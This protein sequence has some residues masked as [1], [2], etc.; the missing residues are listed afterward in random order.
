MDEE[1]DNSVRSE[2]PVAEAE[3]GPGGEADGEG[4]KFFDVKNACGGADEVPELAEGEAALKEALPLAEALDEVALDFVA[5]LIALFGEGWTKCFYSRNWQCRVAAL[6]HLSASMSRRLE[7]LT[8]PEVP[9]NALGEL[10]DGAMRAVHEG[11][12][13]QNVRVYAEACMSVTAVVPAFCGAV[14]GRLLV[15]HLAPLLRQLCARM[16]DS[17]EVVPT[18]TTQA[19]FRLLNPPTGNIVSPIAIAMLILRHLAPSKEEAGCDSPTSQAKSGQGKGNPIGWLCRLAALRDLAKEH[20]KSIVQ[21]PGSTNPG[22]WLRLAEGLK[23]SD[24]TVRHE[25]MRLY[26]LVCKMHLKSMGD[27][28]AQRPAREVW[29]AALPVDVP[30]KSMEQVRKYLKLPEA[31]QAA[32]EK[33]GEAL[34]KSQ[35]LAMTITSMPWEVPKN[36]AVWAGCAPEVLTVLSAPGKGDEKTVLSAL[37]A[38]GKGVGK[39][40]KAA[41]RGG[42]STDEAFAHICRAIQQALAFPTGADRYVFLCAVEL[43]QMAV[44]QLSPA[45]SGLDINMGL[46]KIFPTL[47]ERTAVTGATD[48]KVGVASDKFVQQ[49]AKH[50]KVGCEAVTKMV[51]N[52]VARSERPVRP[53]VLLRTLLSDFG[54]RLCAQRDVVTLL[55][56]AIAGHLERIGK[57]GEEEAEAVRTQLI[58]VLATC[59]QFSPETVHFCM[60]E[61]DGSQ[62][63]LLFAALADAPNPRLVALGATAAEQDSADV[64]AGSAVRAASRSRGNSRQPSPASSP[65]PSPLTRGSPDSSPGGAGRPPAPLPAAALS[66]HNSR[67]ALRP[68]EDSGLRRSGS[69]QKIQSGDASPEVR[70]SSR[71]R[72]KAE[73]SSPSK[74]KGQLGGHSEASTAASTEFSTESPR[75]AGLRQGSSNNLTNSL[76]SSG[77]SPWSGSSSRPPIPPNLSSALN[78]RGGD[79][80]MSWKFKE[81]GAAEGEESGRHRIKRQSSSDGKFG[82]EKAANDGLAGI[83]DVL[84]QMEGNKT[85]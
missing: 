30:A 72:R 50:P 24:P 31:E 73:E 38:L 3:P 75:F 46:G 79:G 60:S 6:T 82:R 28:E 9:Q 32:E 71:R 12:G 58:G 65:G 57:S 15:A 40:E 16:G 69:S 41:D 77:R 70:D 23:H 37:K 1:S 26:T 21:H 78:G 53:L 44:V 43:C 42:S 2:A 49:M 25:S 18:Q 67:N 4:V 59:N 7:E 84:S 48:V 66:R 17:K 14:D 35:K 74:S 76:D 5:P 36:L 11:L 61:V 13:D 81:E 64:V 51:I 52:S 45:L 54:L 47:L 83:M 19:I 56:S 68:M 22:E 33:A 10:L 20:T 80:S 63:K 55:L 85:R 29:A 62:R 39:G 27:E 34:Q 8:G